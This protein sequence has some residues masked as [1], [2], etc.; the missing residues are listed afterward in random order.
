MAKAR[1]ELT[2]NLAEIVLA[3]PPLNLLGP[4]LAK[5]LVTVVGEA[6]ESTARAV[7]VRAEGANFSAGANVEMFVGINEAAAR[8]LIAGF[9]PAIRRFAE[10]TIPSVAAVQGLCLAGGLE[11]ALGCDIIWAADDARLGL[12]EGVIGATPFGGGA[13]RLVARAG[14][15][16]AAEA[17]YT[18]RIYS[19]QT[20]LDWGVVNRV[21]PTANLL[22]KARSFSRRLSDG[23][24]VAHAATR[25]MIQLTVDQ[26]VAAADAA[27]LDIGPRVMISEDLQRGARV[28]LE[29]GPGHATFRGR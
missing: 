6:A 9:L 14:A 1:L 10:L 8:E 19:A 15:G 28:L 24:T 21:V 5:D 16:R 27:I 22:E 13:Q 11:V 23:P 29:Q 18:A 17:V 4:E 25:R 26:G 20:M 3:D 12:A 2:G 7:L